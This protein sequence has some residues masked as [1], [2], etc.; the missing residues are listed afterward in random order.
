M[1]RLKLPDNRGLYFTQLFKVLRDPK[2]MSIGMRVYTQAPG[3][4]LL[5]VLGNRRGP[6][7]LMMN[8]VRF[9]I[10]AMFLRN[11]WTSISPGL[12][13]LE[14]NQSPIPIPEEAAYILEIPVT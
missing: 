4:G 14:P 3:Y 6:M 11:D 9:S 1:I 13:R 7:N 5:F 10:V 2:E 12:I 8:G